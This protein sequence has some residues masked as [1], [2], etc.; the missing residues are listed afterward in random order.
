MVRLNYCCSTHH[1]SA[2]VTNVKIAADREKLASSSGKFA[3]Y[4]TKI[5]EVYISY[6]REAYSTEGLS[7]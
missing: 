5:L 3:Q 2:F 1:L 4:L 7:H 6:H